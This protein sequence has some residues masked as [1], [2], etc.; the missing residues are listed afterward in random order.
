MKKMGYRATIRW[1]A[2]NDEP[3]FLAIE[4]IASLVSVQ[5]AAFI[6][7]KDEFDVAVDI[8]DLRLAEKVMED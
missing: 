5:L 7:C 2:D 8:S 1:I 6:F 4:N 3:T